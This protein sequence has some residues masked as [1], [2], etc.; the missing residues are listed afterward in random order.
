M[1]LVILL[2]PKKCLQLLRNVPEVEGIFLAVVIL[3]ITLWP[4]FSMC[5][6]E[7][8]KENKTALGVL[9]RRLLPLLEW[10][11]G[12]P[13]CAATPSRGLNV[14]TGKM[15]VSNPLSASG[16]RW[17]GA[18][19]SICRKIGELVSL[20]RTHVAAQSPFSGLAAHPWSVRLALLR[21]TLAAR[22]PQMTDVCMSDKGFRTICPVGWD[23]W[24]AEVGCGPANA[25]FRKDAP[26]ANRCN[27]CACWRSAHG[28]AIRRAGWRRML[29]VKKRTNWC[30][31]T[32]LQ[33][34]QSI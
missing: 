7:A 31:W 18:P 17:G 34:A 30:V 20:A 12:L 9:S 23:F 15:K 21:L 4:R 27:R 1:L 13:F 26:P 10:Q 16:S 5:K 32:P 2:R 14:G 22:E 25:V 3:V 33:A 24:A 29:R 8:L 28:R 11:T 6:V 19:S